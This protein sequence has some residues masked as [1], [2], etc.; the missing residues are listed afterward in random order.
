MNF[1]PIS[2]LRIRIIKQALLRNKYLYLNIQRFRYRNA[3]FRKKIIHSDTEI[4]IEGVPRCANSFAVRAFKH[5]NGEDRSI[6]THLHVALHIEMAVTLNV[7]VI[8]LIREP[9]ACIISMAALYAQANKLTYHESMYQYP[10]QWMLLDYIN[11]YTRLKK[12]STKIVVGVFSEVTSDFGA[13]MKRVNL[14]F[15]SSFVPFDHSSENMNH[16]FNTSKVH[17]SP[18]PERDTIKKSF[19]EEMT[20]LQDSSDFQQA[21]DLFTFWS[22]V[23]EKQKEHLK[24][25]E[26]SNH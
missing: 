8:M 18:S 21:V 22:D 4:M 7:P 6:A 10:L 3:P 16:I 11:F 25:N 19:E 20:R 9:R 23:A 15:D 24:L 5:A 12:L 14:M 2:Y 13:V 17:L 1:S 26:F